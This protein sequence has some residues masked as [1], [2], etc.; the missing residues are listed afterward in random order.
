ML[1]LLIA[2]I[3]IAADQITKFA[4]VRY[5]KPV[6]DIPI[7]DGIFHLNFTT[8]KGA[9]WGILEGRRWT[10]V[11]ITVISFVVILYMLYKSKYKNSR[12]FCWSMALILGGA[13]GNFV[14]R[15]RMGEVVDMFYVKLIDFPVFNVADIALT[16][17]AICLIIYMVFIEG[18]EDKNGK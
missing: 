3:V 2:V 11:V 1:W 7:L 9:S 14:D 5:L 10:F 13:A 16:A 17:G 6:G 12:L 15:V 8:N 4:A 18:K